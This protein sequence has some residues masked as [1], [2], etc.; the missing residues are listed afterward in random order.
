MK[1]NK[2]KCQLKEKEAAAWKSVDK[3]GERGPFNLQ[4]IP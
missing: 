1:E 4:R 2:D 3:Q